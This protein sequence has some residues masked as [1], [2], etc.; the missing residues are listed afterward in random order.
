MNCAGADF[1]RCNCALQKSRMA[2]VR[3][4]PDPREAVRV[5]ERLPGEWLSA[6]SCP[7]QLSPVSATLV[8]AQSRGKRARPRPSDTLPQPMFGE[9]LSLV[10]HLVRDQGVGGSNPLSPTN[11]I[12]NLHRFLARLNSLGFPKGFPLFALSAV[13]EAL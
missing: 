2:E 13:G 12:N 5:R 1:F 11:K 3:A 7:A 6:R 4:T 10:E 8:K 9:W